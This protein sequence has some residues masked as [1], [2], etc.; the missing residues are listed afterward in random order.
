LLFNL[1]AGNA[2]A[3]GTKKKTLPAILRKQAWR[4]CKKMLTGAFEG[5]T[6]GAY[7]GELCK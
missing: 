6:K 4:S 7:P 1:S 5:S 2:E 3:H